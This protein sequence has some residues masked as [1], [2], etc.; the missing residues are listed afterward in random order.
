MKHMCLKSLVALLVFQA[1]YLVSPSTVQAEEMTCQSPMMVT[2]DVKPDDAVN[3]INLAS[4]GQLP[5]A[6]LS[7]TMFDAGQFL[8]VMA[9][10]QDARR[11]MDCE[12]GKAIR[13]A[14]TD[15][16]GDGLVDLVFFFRIQ[17]LNLSPDTTEVML[18]AHGPYNGPD[19]I[20]IMGTEDVIVKP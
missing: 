10:L 18:M 17:E 20:H 1:L 13:W 3:K 14:Y 15:V 9:H 8:P 6:V 16:N 2:I 12:S 7:T 5:V 4:R 11:P 19:E